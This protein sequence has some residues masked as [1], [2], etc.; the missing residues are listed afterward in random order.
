MLKKKKKAKKASSISFP[1]E[2]TTNL[3]TSYNW[4]I[5][6]DRSFETFDGTCSICAFILVSTPYLVR[7]KFDCIFLDN[8][9]LLIQWIL[10]QLKTQFIWKYYLFYVHT[11]AKL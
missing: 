4:D 11:F 10:V 7:H 8:K 3:K 1:S 6:S 2:R 9:D 5:E